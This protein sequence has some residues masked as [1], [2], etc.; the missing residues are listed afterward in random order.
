MSKFFLTAFMLILLASFMQYPSGTEQKKDKEQN[1]EATTIFPLSEQI[2][3][4]RYEKRLTQ[5]ELSDR[6]GLSQLNLERI[7]KGKVLPTEDILNKLESELDT[8]FNLQSN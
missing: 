5:K 8:H 1:F 6:I 7:E 4:A 2:K 3:L